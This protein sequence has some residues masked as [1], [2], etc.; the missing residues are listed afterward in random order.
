MKA[1]MNGGNAFEVSVLEVK[2]DKIC[3]GKIFKTPEALLQIVKLELCH[4]FVLRI[5]ICYKFW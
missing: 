2:K 1:E 5:I 3:H 4:V